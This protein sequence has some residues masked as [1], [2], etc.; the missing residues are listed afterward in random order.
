MVRD[1]VSCPTRR[2]VTGEGSVNLA[3]VLRDER[4]KKRAIACSPHVRVYKELRRL[5]QDLPSWQGDRLSLVGVE[6]KW[7]RE[8]ASQGTVQIALKTSSNLSYCLL[9]RKREEFQDLARLQLLRNRVAYVLAPTK[10]KSLPDA[11]CEWLRLYSDAE[12]RIS[13]VGSDEKR[14]VLSVRFLDGRE[15][16]LDVRKTPKGL[17]DKKPRWNNVEISEDQYYVNVP[18]RTGEDVTIPW[19]GI[20]HH[21]R[22]V[23]GPQLPTDMK[24]D[25]RASLGKVGARVSALRKA[26]KLTQERLGKKARIT[27]QTVNRLEGGLHSPSLEVLRKLAKALDTTVTSLLPS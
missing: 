22:Q 16:E 15:F 25:P 21:G 2:N 23:A 7:F 8:A 26:R 14:K 27:R 19:D 18:C 3:L 17:R 4:L 10:E 6:F 5:V 13:K 11:L 20:Q 1:R 12:R 24:A 9:L